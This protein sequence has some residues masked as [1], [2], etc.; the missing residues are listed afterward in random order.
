MSEEKSGVANTGRGGAALSGGGWRASSSTLCCCNRIQKA[1]N[2]HRKEAGKSKNMAPGCASILAKAFCYP[3]SW[4]NMEKRVGI[5]EDGQYKGFLALDNSLF[6]GKCSPERVRISN[7]NPPKT[8]SALKG[9]TSQYCPSDNHISIQVL[10]GLV[11]QT[12]TW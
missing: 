2:L 4:Q 7:R 6:G 11:T 8:S 9:P 12:G 3:N 10:E 5:V 1:G